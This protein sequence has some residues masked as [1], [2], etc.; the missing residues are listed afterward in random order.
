M[1]VAD[2]MEEDLETRRKRLIFRS[3]FTGTRESDLLLG[4][5]A[6]AYLPGFSAAELDAYEALLE[7]HEDPKIFAWATGTSPVPAVFDTPV[8]RLLQKFKISDQ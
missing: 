5:F 2:G 3:C 1:D 4:P 7:C 8:M 6:K